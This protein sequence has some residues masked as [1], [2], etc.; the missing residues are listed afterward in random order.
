MHCSYH[1]RFTNVTK[2]LFVCVCVFFF[3]LPSPV[4][5]LRSLSGPV[6]LRGT[7]STAMPWGQITCMGDKRCCL[8]LF[9]SCLVL[10]WKFWYLYFC[11]TVLLPKCKLVV[12]TRCRT[13]AQSSKGFC[14]VYCQKHSIMTSSLLFSEKENKLTWPVIILLVMISYILSSKMFHFDMR[15]PFYREPDFTH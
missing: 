6:M 4:L 1:Y 7:C 15:S 2:H 9:I 14:G 8:W 10:E 12:S 5:V 13:C 3:P 11:F